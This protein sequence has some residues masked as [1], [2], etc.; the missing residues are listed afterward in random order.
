[1]SKDWEEVLEKMGVT[2]E[3]VQKMMQVMRNGGEELGV[4]TWRPRR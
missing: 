4:Q 1:M 2:R 3:L